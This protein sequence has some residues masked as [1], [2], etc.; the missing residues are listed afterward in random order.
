[1]KDHA[2]YHQAIYNTHP[3]V[4]TIDDTAGASDKDGNLVVIDEAKVAPEIAKLEAVYQATEYQR[5]RKF[6]YPDVGDQLD[7][8][9]HK[10]MFSDEMAA[11]L[12]AV[13]DKYPKGAN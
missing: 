13:K 5:Q 11:K 2:F 8:L 9:Y 12:K 1:M 6:S 10:G 4:V 3:K 7:D